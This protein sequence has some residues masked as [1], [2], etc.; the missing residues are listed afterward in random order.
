M[1]FLLL[2]GHKIRLLKE[3]TP[4]TK[5]GIIN[6]LKRIKE[7]PVRPFEV[8]VDT[9]WYIPRITKWVV[10]VPYNETLDISI[11]V[12]DY[13]VV[14]AWVNHNKDIHTTLDLSKYTALT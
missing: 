13:K 14:T 6:C 9:G 11:A 7:K 5:E 8:E 1:T 2:Q 12:R 3:L 4:Q 10:R